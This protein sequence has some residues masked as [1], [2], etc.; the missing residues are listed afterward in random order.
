MHC[1]DHRSPVDRAPLVLRLL[2]SRVWV[3]LKALLFVSTYESSCLLASCRILT[4]VRWFWH[5]VC[6]HTGSS[7]NTS[8]RG[9]TNVPY[10]GWTQV[11]FNERTGMSVDCSTDLKH[12]IH[13]VN[14]ILR[15]NILSLSDSLFNRNTQIP[16]LVYTDAGV[17][18]KCQF[19]DIL[20]NSA[21]QY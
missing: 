11:A 13:Y 17:I 7:P 9:E 8:Y 18:V 15:E 16:P 12:T 4:T 6:S 19:V 14:S 1:L 21:R 10:S 2:I 20:F 5:A 3:S